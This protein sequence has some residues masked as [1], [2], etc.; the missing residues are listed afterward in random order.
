MHQGMIPDDLKVV[1]DVVDVTDELEVSDLMVDGI[2]QVQDECD[3][4]CKGM[5]WLVAVL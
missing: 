1:L 3:G 2:E 5:F 4:D